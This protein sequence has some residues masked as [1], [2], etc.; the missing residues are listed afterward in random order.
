MHRA[1][2]LVASILLLTACDVRVRRATDSSRAGAADSRSSARTDSAPRRTGDSLR[3]PPRVVRH[4]VI[5]R[6]THGMAA[7]V[8]WVLSPDRLSLILVE[9]PASVEAD[10]LPNGAIFASETRGILLQVEE[11]W[12]VAPSPD[13]KWLA[14]AQA[15][16]L[17][18]E[19]RDSASAKRWGPVAVQLDNV[20][21][22]AGADPSRSADRRRDY[23]R[24]LTATGFPVSG[25]TY[26]YG[27]ASTHVL[28]VDAQQGG[29]RALADTL[30]PVHFGGWRLRWVRGDTLAIGVRPARSQDDAPASRWDLVVVQGTD[31]VS[32]TVAA[33]S[34]SARFA[35]IVWANGPTLDITSAVDA[36]T[37]TRIDAGAAH[38]ESRGGQIYLTRS[39]DATAITIGPGIP[40]AATA[41]AR[42]IAALAPR[43]DRREHETPTVAVVYE[44]IAR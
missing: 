44:V 8:R 30:P 13:W 23:E 36:G 38:L 31:S 16:V 2:S 20:A 41:N 42:Y 21:V 4:D 28:R 24:Q 19:F 43:T 11:I 18:G 15:F 7:R 3:L 17:R 34:D 32:A 29:A 33:A 37:N 5:A 27:A 22:R 40:L 6:G 26:M 35:T 9:D 10:P 39:G 14:Y 25:M 12:D 1:A